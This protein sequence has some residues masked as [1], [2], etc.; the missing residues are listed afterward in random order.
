MS[1]DT[2]SF[3][4]NRAISTFIKGGVSGVIG[5][6]ITQ[7]MDVIKNNIQYYSSINGNKTN[8]LSISRSI[9]NQTGFNGMYRGLAV[10]ILTFAPEKAWIM[11]LYNLT[12]KFIEDNKITNIAKS[13]LIGGVVAGF[14]QTLISNPTAYLKIHRQLNGTHVIDNLRKTSVMTLYSGMKW[15]LIRDIK[16]NSLLFYSQY[17]LSQ[18]SDTSFDKF[19]KGIIATI[20]ACIISTPTDVL[21]TYAIMKH[22]HNVTFKDAINLYYKKGLVYFMT[23]GLLRLTRIPLYMG[24]LLGIFNLLSSYD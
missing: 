19:Y 17:Q 7:P 23:G 24:T 11:M 3:I 21:R 22:P 9:Y 14:G 12:Q 10:Q 6:I 1:S 4:I 15:S 18:P 5:V 13:H 16:F 8:V 2:N 20:P